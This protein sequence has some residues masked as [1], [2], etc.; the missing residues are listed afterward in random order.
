MRKI[1]IW[2]YGGGDRRK[3]GGRTWIFPVSHCLWSKETVD[4]DHSRENHE[5][6]AYMVFLTKKNHITPSLGLS[7]KDYFPT[8]SSLGIIRAVL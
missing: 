8:H 6:A 1:H 7:V 2:E 4:T 3:Q 5:P